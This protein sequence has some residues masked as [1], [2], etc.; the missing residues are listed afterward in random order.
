VRLDEDTIID[1]DVQYH[2]TPL[3]TRIEHT[4]KVRAVCMNGNTKVS[5]ES[6][7]L[8]L[9]LAIVAGI[10]DHCGHLRVSIRLDTGHTLS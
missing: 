7:S 8:S 4:R 3:L 9:S 2:R 1:T 10:V 5:T 6:L